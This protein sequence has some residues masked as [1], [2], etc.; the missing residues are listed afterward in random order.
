METDKD[1]GIFVKIHDRCHLKLTKFFNGS[2]SLTRMETRM[3]LIMQ[4][5]N[6]DLSDQAFADEVFLIYADDQ[7]KRYL[8][9]Q[10]MIRH[11]RDSFKRGD[12]Y[13]KSILETI[14]PK[15]QD[16]PLRE[17]CYRQQIVMDKRMNEMEKRMKEMEHT[18]IQHKKVKEEFYDCQAE[19]IQEKEYVKILQEE[20]ILRQKR[21]L[22]YEQTFQDTIQQI[23]IQL[24]GIECTLTSMSTSPYPVFESVNRLND[25]KDLL[26]KQKQSYVELLGI[27]E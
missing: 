21:N 14:F 26:V 9:E 11:A 7:R 3:E 27:L 19:L 10:N 23:E 5:A 20:E 13:A 12:V 6:Q 18:L 25:R 17:L 4:S 1:T 2:V 22:H 15:D 8:A 16:S 24:K